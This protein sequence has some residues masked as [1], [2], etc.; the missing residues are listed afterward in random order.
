[1][2]SAHLLGFL[3]LAALVAGCSS[4]R[5]PAAPGAPGDT[6]AARGDVTLD[7]VSILGAWYAVEV[8]GDPQA[9]DDLAD[10]TMEQ[11][12]IVRSNGR[13]VLTGVDRRAG[14]SPVS[15]NGR[16]T[17]SRVQFTGMEGAGTLLMS[18]RRLLLRSPDG[19]ST[20]FERGSR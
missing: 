9:T 17:G 18:G 6:A 15:F 20:V 19:R 10:G 3:A 2:R 14:G 7:G 8:V 16:V 4:T 11:T 5:P 13:T 12:L 1:M